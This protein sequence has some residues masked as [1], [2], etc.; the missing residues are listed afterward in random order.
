MRGCHIEKHFKN[1]DE[2]EFGHGRLHKRNCKVNIA[3]GLH[4]LRTHS[5]RYLR[6]QSFFH[7]L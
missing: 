3:S 4:L 7:L 6:I 5:V 2:R 1:S